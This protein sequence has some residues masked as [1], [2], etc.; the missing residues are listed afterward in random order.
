MSYA[1]LALDI[2]TKTGWALHKPGMERPHFGVVPL[3]GKPGEIGVRMDALF[4]F[5]DDQHRMHGLTDICMEAQHVPVAAKPKFGKAPPPGEERRP[6]AQMNPDTLRMLLGLSALVEMYAV[7]IRA[8][9]FAAP[10]SSWRKWFIGRGGQFRSTK[11]GVPDLDPKEMAIQR[12]QALGWFIEQPDAAEAAGILD[13]YL[14]RA[15]EFFERPWR[16]RDLFR[17]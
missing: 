4:R 7:W 8:R 1:V 10:I 12:C 11:P 2:A 17:R 5:L 15:P 14:S 13:F 3:P 16:D 6:I 9:F